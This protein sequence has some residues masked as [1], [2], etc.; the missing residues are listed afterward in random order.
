MRRGYSTWRRRSGAVI[1]V[2]VIVAVTA[3]AYG[4]GGG[5]DAYLGGWLES[6]QKQATALRITDVTGR[7]LVDYLD[8]TR[9]V[10][11]QTVFSTEATAEGDGLQLR[12]ESAGGEAVKGGTLRLSGDG[13]TVVWTTSSGARREFRKVT[14]LP[15]TAP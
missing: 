14:V 9:P 11:E 12:Y 13:A 1:Q 8:L 15:T 10:E 2:A 5:G 6:S 4:C 7:V 3:L